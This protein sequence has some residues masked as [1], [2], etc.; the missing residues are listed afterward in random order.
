ML[1]VRFHIACRMRI[2]F[3]I[4]FVVDRYAKQ[5]GAKHFLVSAKLNRGIEELFLELTQVML[6]KA[7][8][9][10]RAKEN[11][12]SRGGSL[13]RNVL[14]V[15]DEDVDELSGGYRRKCCSTN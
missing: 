13:R 2:N 10:N 14:I 8:E 11:A 5:V 15:N 3:F 6:Q 4:L 7:E 12:M 1:F 9:Q